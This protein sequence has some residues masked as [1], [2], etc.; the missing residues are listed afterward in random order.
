MRAR[1]LIATVT[2]IAIGLG[3]CSQTPVGI[4]ESIEREREILDDRNLDNDLHIGAIA[5]AGGNYFVAAGSLM[6]RGRQD[7]D[8]INNDRQQ[9]NRLTP[10]ADASG[11][12][13]AVSL[14]A[15]DP[16]GAGGP[17]TD[18]IYVVFR[19]QDGTASGI[20]HVDPS[21][22]ALDP[23]PLFGTGDAGV[24]AVEDLFVVDDGSGDD[25]LLAAVRTGLS[26]YTLMFSTS[27]DVSN[28][29]DAP[30]MVTNQPVVSAFASAGNVVLLTPTTLYL[31]S[32]TLAGGTPAAPLG[33][34]P[35][36]GVRFS[37][38]RYEVS[39]S[40]WWVS[41]GA[42]HLST[43]PDLSAWTTNETAYAISP[44]NDDP[45]PFTA[46]IEIDTMVDNLLLVGTNGYGYRILGADALVTPL[47]PIEDGSNYDASEL[48]N[49]AILTWFFDDVADGVYD[50]YPV[51]T[52]PGADPYTLHDGHMLFAGT[53]GVGLWHA[54]TYDGPIQW[55][56]E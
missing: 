23:V 37:D 29:S 31:D 14:V 42:G 9:W 33:L 10:P 12:Y 32:D 43:S 50:S 24:E 46:F 15:F 4:F 22:P 54:L 27:V 13:T 8:Y 18:Q 41:D 11:D 52:E 40:L 53:S 21:G 48:A 45:L 36:S 7:A 56:Q 49:A 28:F 34:A 17:T 3:A 35:A 47:S 44:S 19:S 16:D 30:G 6:Y 26:A 38:V 55:V 2:A 39:G 20:Y 25:V 5:L 51:P 1:I